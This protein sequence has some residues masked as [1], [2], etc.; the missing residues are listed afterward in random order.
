MNIDKMVKQAQKKL[1]KELQESVDQHLVEIQ[2]HSKTHAVAAE[3][4]A[5]RESAE[6]LARIEELFP[7]DDS[8]YPQE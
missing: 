1:A 7:F 5:T 6:A 8:I 2:A 3:E 4:R